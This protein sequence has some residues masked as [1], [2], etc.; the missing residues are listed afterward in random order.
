MAEAAL[1]IPLL[2]GIIFFIIEFGNVLYF[3]NTLNQIGRTAARYASITSGYT[4]AGVE[5]A[6][7]ASSL[8]EAS[9]LTLMI[10]PSPGTAI[11]IGDTI[12]VA[13]S[14]NYIPAINPFGLIG[15]STAWSPVL[16]STSVMRSEVSYAP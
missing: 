10:T 8:L 9:K 12:T 6:S 13:T 16:M 3:T 2:L 4:Q 15:S 14:Y 1:I 11:S 7:G 5:S